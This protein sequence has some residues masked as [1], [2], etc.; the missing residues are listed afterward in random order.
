MGR[1]PD[2]DVHVHGSQFVCRGG[3]PG[4]IHRDAHHLGIA[5]IV[6]ESWQWRVQRALAY[7][8]DV[9]MSKING[10]TRHVALSEKERQ[11]ALYMLE[12]R[13]VRGHPMS[14]S[15]QMRAFHMCFQ[16]WGHATCQGRFSSRCIS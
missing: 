3:K 15:F 14:Q 16:G 7:P 1:V 11:L 8:G 12:E 2:E 10:L 9:G 13:D 6:W 5:A 4:I